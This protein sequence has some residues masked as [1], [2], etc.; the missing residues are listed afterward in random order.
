MKKL[1]FIIVIV[2]A[3]SGT[4]N[5]QVLDKPTPPQNRAWEKK[6][7]P[8]RRYVPYVYLREQDVMWAKR[9]WRELDLRQ[10]INHPLYYPKQPVRDR[11]S[12]PQ[13]LWDAVTNGEIIAYED[14]DFTMPKTP[15]EVITEN[16]R[17][18]STRMKSPITGMDTIIVSTEEFNAGDVTKFRI[19]E[20]WFFDKQRSMMDVRIL[21][22][23]PI[24]KEFT[25]DPQTGERI[26]KGESAVFWIYFPEARPILAKHECYNR[27]ND[28]ARLTYDDIFWKRMFGSYIIKEENVYD[29]FIQ[30]YKKGLDA[31]LEAKGIKEQVR[32]FEHDLWEY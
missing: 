13:V 26:E 24:K 10:K 32:N 11:I 4:S 5:A 19:T 12:L 15:T 14:E 7:N 6:N 9:I 22:L 3:F 2:I 23:A 1:L 27:H 20:D 30:D 28:G 18:D 31:L 29:R 17:V 25:I 16:T 21:G 8:N